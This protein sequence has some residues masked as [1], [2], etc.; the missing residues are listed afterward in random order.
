MAQHDATA[1]I[2]PT[3]AAS[4]GRNATAAA[5]ANPAR[6]ASPRLGRRAMRIVANRQASRHSAAG[7]VVHGITQAD[8]TRFGRAVV[9]TNTQ[10]PRLR[11]SAARPNK[12][13]PMAANSHSDP[14]TQIRSG[15]MNGSVGVS[16][17]KAAPIR[18]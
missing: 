7:V 4:A 11:P 12:C 17:A 9:A 14:T 3:T 16:R 1:Q 5:A 10:A 15:S 13:P 6:K 2:P 18:G 8:I